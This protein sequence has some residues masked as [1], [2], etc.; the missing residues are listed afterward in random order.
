[1]CLKK[2]VIKSKKNMKIFGGDFDQK[3]K[4]I[5][6]LSNKN[7]LVVIFFGILDKF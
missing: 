1:M 5:W 3:V 2:I 7:I 6:Y 4:S